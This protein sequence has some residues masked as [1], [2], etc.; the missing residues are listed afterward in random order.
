MIAPGITHDNLLITVASGTISRMTRAQPPID[1]RPL[2]DGRAREP[3]EL[4]DQLRERLDR[5]AANHPSAPRETAGL[6]PAGE[7]D[8]REQP[9][10]A[11]QPESAAEPEERPEADGPEQRVDGAAPD[12]AQ[13]PAGGQDA[14]RA[15]SPAQAGP[16]GG[17]GGGARLDLNLGQQGQGD[18]YRP[19]FM[20]GDSAEPWFAAGDGA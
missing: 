17:Q 8:W 20:T 2:G 15:D 18:A 10:Q 3:A 9:E 7:Q 19:W 6:D 14:L 12:G 16:A 1:H 13:A 4:L 11:E 5:L